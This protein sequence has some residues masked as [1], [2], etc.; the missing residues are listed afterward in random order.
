MTAYVAAAL[1]EIGASSDRDNQAIVI[2]K[3][4]LENN[5]Y[6]VQDPCVAAITTYALTMLGSRTAL[7][8]Q[9]IMET[10]QLPYGNDL[11]TLIFV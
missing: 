3:I 5:M 7:L 8:S 6:L 4:Y 10:M 2:A 9:K 11:W 1:V